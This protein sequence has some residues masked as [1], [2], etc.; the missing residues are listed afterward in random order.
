[1]CTPVSISDAPLLKI[2]TTPYPGLG[3]HGWAIQT[4]SYL[5]SLKSETQGQGFSHCSIWTHSNQFRRIQKRESV[6]I[7]K[8]FG[9]F[10]HSVEN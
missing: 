6:L 3:I 1:M 8:I 2:M 4:P 5:V 9:F 7:P 10:I